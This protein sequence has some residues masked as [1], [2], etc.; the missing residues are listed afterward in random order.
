VERV[1]STDAARRLTVPAVLARVAEVRAFVRD[2]AIDAGGSDAVVADAVQAIDEA[3]TNV[4]V[5]GYA[6]QSGEIEVRTAVR[7]GRFELRLLDRGPTF[8][9]TVVPEPDLSVPPLERRPG[10]MGVHL[11]RRATQA[12]RHRPR[13]GGGNEL[14]LVCDVGGPP[15]EEQTMSLS[16]ETMQPGHDGGVAVVAL[17]GEL[18]ASNYEWLIERVRDVYGHGARALVLDLG[19]LTFMASS[20]LVALYSVVR[21]M[22]GDA[23]PDPDAGWSV[24]HAMEEDQDA[25]SSVV[26]LAAV[27]PAVERVLDRTGLKRLFNVDPTSKAAVAALEAG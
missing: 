17:T 4:I 23:P 8:D 15:Q 18:D 12:A 21:I 7:A 3:A 19:A 14:I 11:I 10:G 6:G 25:A 5:H 27:Q 9:P 2:A 16:I 20:G 13:R 1:T 22:R 24:I 26:R